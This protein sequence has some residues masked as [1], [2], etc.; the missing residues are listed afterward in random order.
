MC[1]QLGETMLAAFPG[2]SSELAPGQTS[3]DYAGHRWQ[4]DVSPFAGAAGANS[5][6]WVPQAVIVTV[7]SPAGGLIRIDT[8]RLLR[9]SAG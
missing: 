3:G 7:R 4:V 2:M 6:V 8:V 1:G 9:R 5:S